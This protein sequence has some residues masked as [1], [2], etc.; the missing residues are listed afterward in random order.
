MTSMEDSLGVPVVVLSRTDGAANVGRA[1]RS[2]RA[3]MQRMLR[4]RSMLHLLEQPDG[5]HDVWQAIRTPRDCPENSGLMRQ[6]SRAQPGRGLRRIRREVTHP[7][8]PAKPSEE[9]G[10]GDEDERGLEMVL[11]P[12]QQPQ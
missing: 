4:V 8:Q 9:D 6:F 11:L 5:N 12:D 10:R 2:A 3:A 7:H 1:T